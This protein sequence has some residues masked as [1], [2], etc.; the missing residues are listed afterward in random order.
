MKLSQRWRQVSLPNKLMVIST[1]IMAVATLFLVVTA[2]LQYLAAR[3]QF[4]AAE[5]SAQ[6]AEQTS[7][8]TLYPEIYIQ[9]AQLTKLTE[10]EK[11]LLEIVFVNAGSIT[12]YN[13]RLVTNYGV[14]EQPPPDNM[15][16]LEGIERA[17]PMT[18]P[19]KG[20]RRHNHVFEGDELNWIADI[21]S[22]KRKLYIVG[23]ATYEDGFNRPYRFTFRHVYK[24]DRGTFS[25]IIKQ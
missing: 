22:G 18:M 9:G 14:S 2:V 10:G 3:D 4:R 8:L 25:S 23:G 11:P 16:E 6:I 7:R 1:A 20:E 15:N 13:T 5:R 19:S 21:K 24:P 12:A 17:V